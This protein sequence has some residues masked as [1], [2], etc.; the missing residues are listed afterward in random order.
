ME[1]NEMQ[2]IALSVSK[3]LKKIFENRISYTNIFD[4]VDEPNHH[5][6][7]IGF[8]AYDYFSVVFQY[9][10]DII[11]CHIE[12]G[13]NTFVPLLKEKHCYSD[14]D[15]NSYFLKVKEELELR[16]PDKYLRAKGWKM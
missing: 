2:R 13:K 14:T 9:E 7:K 3:E 11:G 12:I 4:V 8:T 5:N 16:I 6:F 10:Q 1:L 15:I